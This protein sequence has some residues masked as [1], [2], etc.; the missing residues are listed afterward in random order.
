MQNSSRTSD[1]DILTIVNEITD[2]FRKLE[3]SHESSKDEFEGTWARN[4]VH[5]QR[6]RFE[7]WTND[8]KIIRSAKRNTLRLRAEIGSSSVESLLQSLMLG[9][10]QAL[11]EGSSW[12]RLFWMTLK[13]YKLCYITR[14]LHGSPT[15][16]YASSISCFYHTIDIL[17]YV[18]R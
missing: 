5:V 17:G 15:W 7:L 9:L 10:L 1:A 18:P 3:T 14:T 13:S 6:Q 8:F 12:H 2:L 16:K 4:V 11:E